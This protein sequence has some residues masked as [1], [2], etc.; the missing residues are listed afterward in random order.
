MIDLRDPVIVIANVI[1]ILE[2][3]AIIAGGVSLLAVGKARGALPGIGLFV[4][5]ISTMI[6]AIWSFMFTW[7]VE[8]QHLSVGATALTQDGIT[9]L[10]DIIG[11]ILVIVAFAR[12]RPPKR[13]QA[14]GPGP[15]APA[16]PGPPHAGPAPGYGAPGHG[17]PGYGG[18]PSGPGY[19]PP[20]GYTGPDGHPS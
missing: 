4:L 16:Y 3:L 15:G 6:G 7:L 1:L 11:W 10:L 20:R 17:G 19:G 12:L 9:A 8:V 18:P 2:A 5:A 13:P 14:Y